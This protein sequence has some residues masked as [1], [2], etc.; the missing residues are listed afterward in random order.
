MVGCA[1]RELKIVEMAWNLVVSRNQGTPIQNPKHYN[2]YYGGPQEV[3]LI[4]G[5]PHFCLCAGLLPVQ[6]LFALW[7]LALWRRVLAVG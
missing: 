3:P 5:H 7:R 2:P 4:L 1:G 6:P